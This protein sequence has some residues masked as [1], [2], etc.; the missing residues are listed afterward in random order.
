MDD[1]EILL[2]FGYLLLKHKRKRRQQAK[3]SRSNQWVKEFSK[4]GQM[5]TI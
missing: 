1:E 2:P 5:K 3:N 4:Q